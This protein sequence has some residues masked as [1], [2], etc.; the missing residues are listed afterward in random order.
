MATKPERK[1]VE[2]MTH[3]EREAEHLRIL[4]ETIEARMSGAQ[5][6]RDVVA[7]ETPDAPLTA[8]P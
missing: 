2:E 8:T 3:E 6:M 5:S 7:T 4:R 1:S